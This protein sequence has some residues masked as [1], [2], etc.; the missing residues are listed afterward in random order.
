MQY[1]ACIVPAAPV[2]ITATHTGEI[3]NQL[4]FGDTLLVLDDS[5]RYWLR[6]QSLYDNYEGWVRRSQME[7]IDEQTATNNDYLVTEDV[8][9]FLDVNGTTMCVPFGSS[10]TGYGSNGGQ[11]GK[12][13]YT[14][15][16]NNACRR[17]EIVP[18]TQRMRMLVE[19]WMHAPYLWGGKTIMGVDCSGFVQVV[20][21]MMGIDMF[22][23]AWQQAGQGE[24]IG[25]L[26]EAQCG[27]L[28]FFDDAEG[29]IVHVGILLNENEIIHS[30]GKV[31][32]DKIDNQGIV[33][34]DTGQRT[35]Q[36]RILRRYFNEQAMDR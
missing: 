15:K 13:R 21:K 2:H 24:A 31:R 35:H 28:A 9:S 23:D 12:F 27:D 8:V 11:L 26:Q 17:N 34:T 20:F 29:K 32:I 25:F 19:K 7:G 1:A 22:R 36:L 4:L 6:I 10:L 14:Y 5:D 30:S 33:N 16:G 18:T 3:T